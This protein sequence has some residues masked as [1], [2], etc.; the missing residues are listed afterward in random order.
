MEIQRRAG[1]VTPRLRLTLGWLPRLAIEP[2]SL[3]LRRP[4]RPPILI[5]RALAPS[6]AEA[7][8]AGPQR[9]TT[10]SP[11][12]YDSSAESPPSSAKYAYARSPAKCSAMPGR[13]DPISARR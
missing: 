12:V 10:S 2:G 9:S 3:R 1:C 7:G 13:I 11:L 8:P 5:F 6:L 4:S